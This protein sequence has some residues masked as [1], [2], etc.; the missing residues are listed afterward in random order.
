V[1]EYEKGRRY[2]MEAQMKEPTNDEIV[3]SALW[4]G[5]GGRHAPPCGMCRLA[6][7][8]VAR[9]ELP[10]P[11]PDREPEPKPTV[12]APPEV[13]CVH[14]FK[15]A[16]CMPCRYGTPEPCQ[17]PKCPC[18][19]SPVEAGPSAEPKLCRR[20]AEAGCCEHYTEP[21]PSPAPPQACPECEDGWVDI[22]NGM[23]QRCSNCNFPGKRGTR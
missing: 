10:A 11:H 5:Y 22:R 23:M 17:D 21:A 9:G 1:T 20:C 13:R 14:G 3:R 8:M 4:H 18:V 16:E 2:S 15:V 7:V 19:A 6:D 12:E